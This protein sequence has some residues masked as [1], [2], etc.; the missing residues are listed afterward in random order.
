MQNLPV[1]Y[2]ENH[3]LDISF[4]WKSISEGNKEL[5][6]PAYGGKMFSSDFKISKAGQHY[7]KSIFPMILLR[8][9]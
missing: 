9:F 6:I 1:D 3:W 8:R 5:G 7:Q 4:L 2:G